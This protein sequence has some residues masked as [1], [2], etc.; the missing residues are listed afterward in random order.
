MAGVS[1]RGKNN[2]TTDKSFENCLV[3]SQTSFE[4]RSMEE[5]LDQEQDLVQQAGIR[6]RMPPLA[7]EQDTEPAVKVYSWDEIR[8]HDKEGDAWVVKGGQVT[9]H[10]KGA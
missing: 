1:Q 7:I 6:H 5:L 3:Q 9:L 10:R 4:F 8:K 2:F